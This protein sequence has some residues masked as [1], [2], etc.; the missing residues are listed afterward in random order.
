MGLNLPPFSVSPFTVTGK[1][2]S[3]F[4]K[5]FFKVEGP[6]GTLSNIEPR[7]GKPR[8]TDKLWEN[9]CFELFLYE[10]PRYVEWNFATNGNWACFKFKDERLKE[11]DLYFLPSPRINS[12]KSDVLTIE[13][14]IPEPHR[15]LVT[16]KMFYLSCVLKTKENSFYH[17]LKHPQD[18]PDFHNSD[19]YFSISRLL[20]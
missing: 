13:V 19:N 17:G 9:T 4:S 6:H 12:K 7:S 15:T 1:L 2:D 10:G 16:P 3:K 20:P 14:E 11:E 5:L 18:T 8:F